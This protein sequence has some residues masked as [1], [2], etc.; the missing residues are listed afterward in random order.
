MLAAVASL[1]LSLYSGFDFDLEKALI[2]IYD[3]I[4]EKPEL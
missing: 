1:K 3:G 4:I 2:T